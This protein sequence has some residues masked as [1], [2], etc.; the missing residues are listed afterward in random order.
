VLGT[1]TSERK[2]AVESCVGFREDMASMSAEQ[3]HFVFF[4]VHC[5]CSFLLAF[6]IARL[7][8]AIPG[9][10]QGGRVGAMRLLGLFKYHGAPLKVYVYYGI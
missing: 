5:Q 6:H 7:G 1:I 3:R 10:T 2:L 8:K 9:E 4:M